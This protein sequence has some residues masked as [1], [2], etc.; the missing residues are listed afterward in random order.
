VPDLG[1]VPAGPAAEAIVRTARRLWQAGLLAGVDG[2]LSVRLD[3]GRVLVTPSGC[4]KADLRPRDLVLVDREGAVLGGFRQATS[5]LDLHLRIYRHCPEAGAVVHAHPPTATGLGLAGE[6]LPAD[7][8]PEVTLQLGDV[9]LVP[10]ATPGTPALGEMVEPYLAGR[11]GLLLANHG[12]VTWGPDLDAARVRMESL[13]H[14]A[15]ILLAARAAGRVNR[16]TA[17]QVRALKDPEREPAHD[18]ADQRSR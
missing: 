15:K 17:G 13:E 14:A 18:Q 1:A 10:Y 7:L 4:P 6:G 12:A 5:E 9:P 3:A 8:L 2:N 16:L 11:S